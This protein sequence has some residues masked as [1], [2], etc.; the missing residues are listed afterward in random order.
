MKGLI[1]LLKNIFRI[2]TK[3]IKGKKL[4]DSDQVIDRDCV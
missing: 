2:N 4:R 1:Y 3:C